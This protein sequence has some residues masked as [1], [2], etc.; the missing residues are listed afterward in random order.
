MIEGNP[1]EVALNVLN[2]LKDKGGL[3]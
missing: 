1:E 2:V 3:A